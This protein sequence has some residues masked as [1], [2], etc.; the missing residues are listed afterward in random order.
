[1]IQEDAIIQHIS[2]LIDRHSA[3]E[4][5]ALCRLIPGRAPTRKAEMADYIIGHLKGAG[6]RS[7]FESMTE[8]E[9]SAVSEVVHS[10]YLAHRD[11]AFR[12]KY[13]RSPRL[14]LARYGKDDVSPLRFFFMGSD[15]VMPVDLKERL[16]AF[17]PKPCPETIRSVD[18]L[19]DSYIRYENQ[20]D[21]KMKT[22]ETKETGSVP[23]AV[24]CTEEAAGRELKSVLR[25][26]D[27]RRLTASEKTRKPSSTAIAQ[28]TEV[29]ESGDY[30]EYGK[31][32]RKYFDENAGPIKAFAWPMILQAGGVVELS[33]G[34]LQLTQKGRR[35]FSDPSDG[36]L[37]L[38]WNRWLKTSLFDELSRIDEIKGQTGR[39]KRSLIAVAKRRA[40]IASVLS[41]CPVDRWIPVDEFF[42]FSRSSNR[43]L[44]VARDYWDFYISD[45][46]YGS[47]GY[48][49]Y[50]ET[51]DRGYALCFLLEYASTLGLIDVA[52]VPPAESA[53]YYGH[54]WGTD[55]LLYLTR[56]DGLA[57]FRLNPLGAYCLGKS[58][59]YSA[60]V[61]KS[62]TILQVLPNFEIV[63]LPDDI[64]RSD[65]IALD[66]YFEKVSDDVWRLEEGK[67]LTLAEERRSLEEITQF[68][69]DRNKGPLPETVAV[70][71]QDIVERT[72]RIVDR[73]MARLIECDDHALALLILNDSGTRRYCMPAGDSHIAVPLA[74][75]SKF[76]RKL[77][78]LGFVVSEKSRVEK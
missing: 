30:Y 60:P 64:P 32:T 12:A 45:G 33:G 42:R 26:I 19:P 17:V 15:Y 50:A 22:Y 69:E 18:E 48:E 5:R 57:Y 47:F 7:V 66:T 40:Q 54:M 21:Y 10:E 73:G 2:G 43:E 75:E 29:L 65:R 44:A 37:R 34:R 4:L 67:L 61:T 13:G 23:L 55:D 24:W 36:Y 71:F 11:K 77:K 20:Y 56:C 41:D 74:S 68:L 8:L 35:A 72:G 59:Y 78:A 6:L 27:S 39:G 25:L 3:D 62:N 70:F 16:K 63:A 51:L 31:P 28:I 49:G 14:S 76:R 38:L 58:E 53:R 1:M 9:R 46:N 52:L